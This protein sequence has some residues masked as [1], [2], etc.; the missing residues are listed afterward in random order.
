MTLLRVRC[1]S[2]NL[3]SDIK[4]FSTSSFLISARTGG[5]KRSSLRCCLVLTMLSRALSVWVP[6]S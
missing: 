1:V 6:T 3:M 5:E 4:S 2:R